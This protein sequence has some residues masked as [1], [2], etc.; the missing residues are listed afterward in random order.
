MKRRD[1]SGVPELRLQSANALQALETLEVDAEEVLD[2]RARV[3]AG[4]ARAQGMEVPVFRRKTRRLTVKRRVI[5][6]QTRN[7]GSDQWEI[8]A[9]FRPEQD[10]RC[11]TPG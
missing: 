6:W 2:D 9:Q 5:D 8:L 1:P 11:T 7:R 10:H 4:V 3:L